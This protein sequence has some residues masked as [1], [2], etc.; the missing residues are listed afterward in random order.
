MKPILIIEDDSFKLN[1][2]IEHIEKTIKGIQIHSATNLVDAIDLISKIECSAII[3]DMAIP[4]HPT[5]IGG[6]SPMSLLTGGLDVILELK[7]LKRN[8]PCIII[9]Q[10]PDIEISG[11]FYPVS[12]AKEEIHKH[13]DCKVLTCISYSEGSN[14]WK[15]ELT[16]T[17]KTL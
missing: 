13:L 11:E 7:E 5:I 17:L 1:S 2:L 6:G 14:N 16:E 4:S 3:V 9:T 12:K 10:Y 8:E 15:S